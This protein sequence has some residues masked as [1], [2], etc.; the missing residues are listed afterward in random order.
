MNEWYQRTETTVDCRKESTFPSGDCLDDDCHGYDNIIIANDIIP[1]Q[2]RSDKST[3]RNGTGSN[4]TMKNI[5]ATPTIVVPTF[6]PL[7]VPPTKS[8]LAVPDD[9]KATIIAEYVNRTTFTNRTISLSGNEPEDKA[10]Q[11]MV[12]KD[13][14]LNIAGTNVSSLMAYFVTNQKLTYQQYR[15]QQRYGLLT[16]WFQQPDPKVSTWYNTTGWVKQFNECTW[17]G[18]DCSI[19]NLGAP[20]GRQRVVTEILLFNNSMTGTISPELGLLSHVVKS[21]FSF[22]R[23]HGTLPSSLG[24]W[25][26]MNSF[27]IGYTGLTGS[28]PE[29][30]AASWTNISYFALDCNLFTGTIPEKIGNYWTNLYVFYLPSN[31]FSGTL[32]STLGQLTSL[33]FVSFENNTFTGT[34]PSEIGQWN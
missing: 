22:N 21:Q 20:L 4:T 10:L 26:N 30:I 29:T 9:E 31:M 5:A 7:P 14:I 34:L 18:I 17:Y 3:S 8:P 13:P 15:F 33:V 24:A 2:C 6:A 25:T 16:I 23:L 12:H 19:I 1:N 28:I 11:W 32:P 27:W